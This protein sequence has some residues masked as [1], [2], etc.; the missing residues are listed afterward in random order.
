MVNDNEAGQHKS[1]GEA[2][3]NGV[4][5]PFADTPATRKKIL[6]D[7]TAGGGIAVRYVR[8]A[9]PGEAAGDGAR[10]PCRHAAA[11]CE[12]GTP[13]AF[14]DSATVGDSGAVRHV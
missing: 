1:A 2:R 6:G 3:E 8:R 7:G 4:H 11:E 14:S 10:A 12:T 9:S 13:S 5:R